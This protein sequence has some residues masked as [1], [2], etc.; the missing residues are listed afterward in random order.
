LREARTKTLETAKPQRVALKTEGLEAAL[1][2][3]FHSAVTVRGAGRTDAG[4]HARGQVIGLLGVEARRVR[5]VRHGVRFPDSPPA[6][7]SAR[8]PTG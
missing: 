7:A 2:A 8:D 6:P 1:A 3:L 5:V 4:V